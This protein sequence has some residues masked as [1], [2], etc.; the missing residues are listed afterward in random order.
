MAWGNLT[1]TVGQIFTSGNANAI[2]ENARQVRISHYGGSTPANL[3]VGV[4]WWDTSGTYPTKKIY[5]GSNWIPM[6]FWDPSQNEAG[7]APNGDSWGTV[8]MTITNGARTDFTGPLYFPKNML[9][10]GAMNYFQ[11]G[12]SFQVKSCR[13]YTADRWMLDN[14]GSFTVNVR[15]SSENPLQSPSR[16]SLQLQIANP[17]VTLNSGNILSVVQPIEGIMLNRTL[18]GTPNA[19]RVRMS[20][21]VWSNVTGRFSFMVQNASRD[22]TNIMAA[23]YNVASVWQLISTGLV[24][25]VSSNWAIDNGVGAWVGVVFAAHDSFRSST[26]SA[27]V[28]NSPDVRCVSGQLQGASTS[29]TIFRITD[30]QLELGEIATPFDTLQPDAELSL[31][32]RYYYKTFDTSVAPRDGTGQTEGALCDMGDNNGHMIT[33]WPFR[34][35]AGPTITY[36]NPRSGSVGAGRWWNYQDNTDAKGGLTLSYG[37]SGIIVTGSGP[38]TGHEFDKLLIHASA[39]AE[40]M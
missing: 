28:Y 23:A 22:S 15:Q 34:M 5:T 4:E 10:N 6:L 31:L 37:D 19:R 27:W 26:P 38:G 29:G 17:Q 9:L 40:L 32:Q 21:Y 8:P 11:R 1:F 3:E 2:Q 14:R 20:A 7:I 16:Y 18:Y 13:T 39:D 35:R 25:P 24:A 36:Y 12:N 33:R 30:L